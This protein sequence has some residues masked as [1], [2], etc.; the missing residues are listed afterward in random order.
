MILTR[1]TPT[2]IDM[3]YLNGYYKVNG[4]IIENKVHALIKASSLQC[5]VSWWYYD[6]IFEAASQN[7]KH[8]ISLTELYR[9]RAQQLRDSYD[10]L[11][12]NY[13]GGSDSHNVLQTFLRNNIKLDAIYVQWPE[14]LMDKGLYTPNAVDKSNANFHS[15]WD[16]VLKKDLEWIGKNYPDIVIEIGD[17][18]KTITENFYTDD[19]FNENVTNLPSIARAQKQHTFSRQESIWANK[20]KKVASIYGVDKTPIVKLNGKWNWY[21]MDTAM[22]ARANPDNPNGTEYFYHTPN[23]PLIP[24]EQGIALKNWFQS[25]PEKEYLVRALPERILENPGLANR[26]YS[27]VYREL[28]QVYEIIKLVCYPYWDFSRFQADKPYAVLEGFKMGTRAW[29]NILTALPNFDRV[30]QKWEYNWRSYLSMMTKRCLR[31][32][33]TLALLRTKGHPINL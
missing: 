1:D 22:M 23:F 9:Q 19:L 16:L 32:Q 17:W 10:Y 31:N 33:D 28:S 3:K 4:E 7:Y 2:R 26:N 13:S 29:D 18:T 14:S 20:G 24:I 6:E 25:H 12:L 11:I 8:R 27:E 21:L 15:E 5:T 30:Q